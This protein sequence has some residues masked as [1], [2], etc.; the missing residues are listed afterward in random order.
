ML[1]IFLKDSNDEVEIGT[2]NLE[3]QKVNSCLSLL[4]DADK[5]AV[6]ISKQLIQLKNDID[7]LEQQNVC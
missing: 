4:F 3:P 7:D 1:C 6:D 5:R 2:T